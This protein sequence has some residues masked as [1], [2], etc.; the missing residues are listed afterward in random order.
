MKPYFIPTKR[1]QYILA[2]I[3]LIVLILSLM[4][5]PLTKMFSADTMSDLSLKVGWPMTFFELSLSDSEKFPI[6]GYGLPI[7]IDMIIYVVI[8]YLIEVFILFIIGFLTKQKTEEVEKKEISVKSKSIRDEDVYKKAKEVYQ[9]Y[10]SKGVSDDNIK[11]LF[12]QK[13]WK[14]DSINKIL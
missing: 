4:N 13:G 11:E 12:K 3:L 7:F 6:P 5:F 14:E 8:A 2:V 9:Y 1:M 10:K